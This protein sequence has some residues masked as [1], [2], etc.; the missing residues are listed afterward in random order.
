MAATAWSLRTVKSF[1][2]RESP[3]EF[4]NRY[5]FGNNAPSTP[6]EWDSL[7]DVVVG[8]ERAIFQPSVTVVEAHGFEPPSDVAVHTKAY[9]QAG[10]LTGGDRCP[11]DCAAVLRQA[12]NKR[13]VKNHPVYLFSYFHGA[14]KDPSDPDLLY[15]TQL[16]AVD[17][18]G[19]AWSTGLDAGG[20]IYVRSTPDNH[21]CTGFHTET[22]VGHRDFQN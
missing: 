1:T 9:G 16:A 10:I 17:A 6:A 2:Y 19:R 5:Y 13:S 18:L 4:S 15:A 21:L 22:Y 11:G 8:L 12:T 20:K 3:R 7:L 14:C